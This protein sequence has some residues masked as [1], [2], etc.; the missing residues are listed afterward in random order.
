M[1]GIAILLLAAGASSR[2][3]GADKLLQE[4]D[5]VALLRRQALV[6]LSSGCA[7]WV[8]LSQGRPARLAALEG[9]DLTVVEVADAGDGMA[10]SIRT[11]VAALPPL[12]R[13][14]VVLPADMPEITAQDLAVVIAGFDGQALVQGCSENGDP[15]HPVLFPA[16]VFPELLALEGDQGARSVLRAHGV[17]RVALPE[18]HALTDLDTPEDWAAWRAAQLAR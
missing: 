5:G 15:G 9:L 14:V 18:A 13:A 8:C 3:R 6:A 10:A 1:K 16:R 4:I 7:V 11:G 12:T 2:M 17:I